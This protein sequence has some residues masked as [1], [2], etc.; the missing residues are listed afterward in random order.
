MEVEKISQGVFEI[1]RNTINRPFYVIKDPNGVIIG[2]SQSFFNVYACEQSISFIRNNAN[3]SQISDEIII[4]ELPKFEIYQ[5]K[6]QTYKF[7]FIGIKGETVLSSQDYDTKE[8]CIN[9]INLIKKYAMNAKIIN[10]T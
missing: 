10:F 1:K 9:A 5:N 4:D 3:I 2:V 7:R 8:D 6:I